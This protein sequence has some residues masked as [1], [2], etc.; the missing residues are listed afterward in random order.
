MSTWFYFDANGQ[1]HGPVS[2][3]QLKGLAKAGRITPETVV[4]TETGKTAP[5]GKVKGLTFI[6]AEQPQPPPVA[7]KPSVVAPPAPA[8]ATTEQDPWDWGISASEVTSLMTESQTPKTPPQAYKGPNAGS[9]VFD[10]IK[11]HILLGG[12][13]CVALVLGVFL[14]FG[15]LNATDIEGKWFQAEKDDRFVQSI[16]LLNDGTGIIDDRPILWETTPEKGSRFV[17]HG[18]LHVQYDDTGEDWTIPYHISSST[19]T[20]EF[21][22]GKSNYTRRKKSTASKKK[23]TDEAVAINDATTQGVLTAAEQAD[24]DGYMNRFGRDV[25]AC[26]LN[27]YVS[28]DGKNVQILSD[29][30]KNLALKYVKYFVSKGMDVNAKDN[31]GITAIHAT[32]LVGHVEIADFLVS[33]G[34]NVQA[35]DNNGTT[36]LHV[37]GLNKNTEIA[38]FL[39]AKGADV[40]VRNNNGITP[41]HSVTLVGNLESIKFL[42]SR[43]ADIHAK[44]NNGVTPLL[45]A[46]VGNGSMEVIQ[47]LISKGADVQ[48]KSGNGANIL[49]AAAFNRNVEIAEFLVSKGVNIQAKT[50]ASVTPLHM[51][52]D[53]GNIDVAQFLI[54]KGVDVNA[55]TNT[56]ATPLD[57]ARAKGHTAV[58]TYL[59]SV[60]GKAGN[61]SAIPQGQPSTSLPGGQTRA[62]QSPAPPM[63][64]PNTTPQPGQTTPRLGTPRIAAHG[65][66]R[67]LVIA[68]DRYNT[69]VRQYPTTEQGLNALFVR[70]ADLPASANWKGPYA[71]LVFQKQRTIDPWG[72]AYQYARPGKNG[73]PFDVWS[74]GPDGKDGTED[75]VGHWMEMRDL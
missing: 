33:K 8:P 73:R 28:P 68:L 21:E 57:Y 65:P 16:E 66:L 43:G 14:F 2:G 71:P 51:A 13:L 31:L 32:A 23:D 41:L 40:N 20:L 50:N 26:Y 34:A 17:R 7:A 49:H 69:D 60:G 18:S 70:P 25:I 29:A 54:S 75:D 4:E 63:V 5:A 74:L 39:V 62:G 55:K 44:D 12:L 61:P 38:P 42:V 72:N 56:G 52:A 9:Q 35:K 27:K 30:E 45:A 48:A 47:F 22:D 46:T 19:L 59:T 67:Q 37:V 10:W 3:G 64:R 58:A 36:P 24:A 11:N 1:K 15:I 53:G 6:A